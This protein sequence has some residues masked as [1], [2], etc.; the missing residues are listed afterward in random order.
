MP[1]DRE[2][3]VRLLGGEDI[4][5]LVDRCRRRMERAQPLT[6][7]VTLAGATSRQRAAVHRLL[8]RSP[9]PGSTLTV[10]L[11]AV[12][13]VV[14]RSGACPDG[15]AAAIVALT[16]EVTDRV[17]ADADYE[18]RWRAAFAPLEAAVA[19]R[20]ELT[21]WLAGLYSTGLVRRLAGAPESAAP[22]L[23][24]L[25]KVISNLPAAGEPLGR[26][27]ARTTGGAHGLDPDRSLA[28]LA[29][30]AARSLSGLPDGSGAEWRREVWASVGVLRDE[31]SSTV[32]TV[33]LPGDAHTST[34]RVLAA[35]H[36]TGQPAVLT[37][38]QLVRDPPRLRVPEVFVCE[39]PVVVATTADRLGAGCLPLICTNGQPGAAVLHLLRQLTSGGTM[40]RYH[41][42][43]DWG[44]L[45]IGNVV[46]ARVPAVPWRFRATD[47]RTV[48]DRGRELAGTPV[49]AAWDGDLGAA[50]G[51]VG[52]AVEEEHVIDD[53]V[54]DL[55]G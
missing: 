20:T 26:F 28:T 30:G 3:L 13:E 17:A 11:S 41:G 40:L 34:G 46:F 18:R 16:G 51:E 49:V 55:A 52:V 42:D 2:R 6:T 24:D 12:D 50:M 31:V 54:T 1:A 35:C 10:S 43:F 8:G 7:S 21:G 45:R 29:L 9:R 37:L 22:L 19:A 33:G 14:R 44:G 39:N 27:A 23:A 47:Y 36:E 25:V 48:A 53:L 32:L 5:W 15:L 38:R 4:A